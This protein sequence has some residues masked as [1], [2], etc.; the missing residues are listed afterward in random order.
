MCSNH[1]TSVCKSA[2][3]SLKGARNL[4][5]QL[6]AETQIMTQQTLD[7][8]RAKGVDATEVENYFK[9]IEALMDRHNDRI[10]Q[11]MAAQQPSQSLIHK[12]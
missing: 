5:K 8:L 11:K 2:E 7:D 12:S 10:D 3:A 6:R 9:R 4:L 1:E